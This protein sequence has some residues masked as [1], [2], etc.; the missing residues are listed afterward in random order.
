MH[1]MWTLASNNHILARSCSYFITECMNERRILA[2][3]A[4]CYVVCCVTVVFIVR[5]V[6]LSQRYA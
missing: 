2:V 6:N 4:R 1:T 3:M 5:Q